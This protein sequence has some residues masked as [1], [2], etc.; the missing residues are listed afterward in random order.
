MLG[1]CEAKNRTKANCCMPEPTGTKD[2]GK[3]VKRIES[4]EEGRVT[5][6]DAKTGES[7]E[8]RK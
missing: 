2:F 1:V 3:L 6:K 7:K 5:A 4:L 8:K